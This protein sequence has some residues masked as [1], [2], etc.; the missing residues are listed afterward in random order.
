MNDEES[1]LWSYPHEAVRRFSDRRHAG[2]LLADLAES[3][4]W[5][6]P[7]VLAIPRGGVV[8]AGEIARRLSC[9]LDVIV[10]RKVGAPGEPELAIGAVSSDGTRIL[11]RELMR[12]LGIERS[13]LDHAC[14]MA[15]AEARSRELRFRIGPAA[16][17]AGRTVVLVDDG[18]ATGA[19]LRA[20]IS[21]LKRQ[22]V[23]E[24]VVAVPVGAREVCHTIARQV[25]EL[26]CPLRPEPFIAVGHHYGSFPQV[27]DGE[28]R[29]VL[30]G[31]RAWLAQRAMR[32]PK[33]TA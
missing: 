4:R 10:A 13:Y 8:V 19:T 29:Q 33:R 20:C 27:S 16:G 1:G 6:D 23:R 2:A 14:A 25:D 12:T 26:I 15:T 28:V 30:S 22:R 9:E 24:L 17:P 11:N 21:A 18:L 7:L 31:H 32:A 5:Q 3:R